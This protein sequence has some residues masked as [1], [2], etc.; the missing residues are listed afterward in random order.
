MAKTEE[1]MLTAGKI[2]AKF[3]IPQAKVKSLIKELNIAPDLVK[4]G[5]NYYSVATAQKIKKAH[6]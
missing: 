2:S 6:G 4:G 3:E 1:E 5:C